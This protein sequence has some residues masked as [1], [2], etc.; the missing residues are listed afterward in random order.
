MAH[1]VDDIIANVIEDIAADIAD[2]IPEEETADGN[3]DANADDDAEA[4]DA[5]DIA[6]VA[7]FEN[8]AEFEDEAE[9]EEETAVDEVVVSVNAEAG[10]SNPTLQLPNKADLIQK[11]VRSEDTTPWSENSERKRVD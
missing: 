3:D 1:D 9:F 8:D 11:F 6:D 2:A 7:N 10:P 5:D 4:A